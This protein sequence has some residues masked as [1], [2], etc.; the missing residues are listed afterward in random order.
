MKRYAWLSILALCATTALAEDEA[1]DKLVPAETAAPVKNTIGMTLVG[2][3]AGTFLMG[4][5]NREP[6]RNNNEE[7]VEVTITK[8]FMIGDT[9]VT[10]EQ[11]TEVMGSSPWEGAVSNSFAKKGS[12]FPAVG[13]TWDD[14]VAFCKE[15]T[16]SEREAGKIPADVSYALPTEA[17]WECACR[18]GS[19]KAFAF[20]HDASKL[21][22]Y[23]W[24]G[25]DI[26]NGNA[27]S[28]RYGHE[29]GSKQPNT[30]KLFD[31]HGNV[32]EWCLDGFEDKLPGGKDPLTPTR[33]YDRVVRG[34]GWT[35]GS[36]SCRSAWRG[37]DSSASSSY[38]RGFR[39]VRTLGTADGTA[40]DTK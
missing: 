26:G 8:P 1:A 2:I 30:L 13:V 34:G 28:E 29:V 3:P 12:R 14:A 24:W 21:S 35:D 38:S 31:M 39:V 33:G 18:A 37:R 4:S 32:S 11:W 20:G 27:A 6:G 10:Q 25:G 23:A 40:E 22:D 15:L 19:K 9:E 5:P 16:E 36:Q 7:Q 17:Q